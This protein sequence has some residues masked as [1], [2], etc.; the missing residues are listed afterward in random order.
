[1]WAVST[2]DQGVE[3]AFEYTFTALV[4]R[5]DVVCRQHLAVRDELT[6]LGECD[7]AA[8]AVRRAFFGEGNCR[9]SCV[10]ESPYNWHCD[11]HR[12]FGDTKDDEYY[13]M[14]AGALGGLDSQLIKRS[15]TEQQ[16]R[17][18]R[19]YEERFVSNLRYQITRL[20]R[21]V[22]GRGERRARQR[23]GDNAPPPRAESV[24]PTGQATPAQQTACSPED[25]AAVAEMRHECLEAASDFT[26]VQARE[27][28]I[29]YCVKTVDRG[30]DV[31]GK[32]YR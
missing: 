22:A 21:L 16:R 10:V 27:S 31:Q 14:K 15:V 7:S 23:S 29:V 19:Q 28:A 25:R 2:D 32:D 4:E 17:I 20:V 9:A 18:T 6:L 30:C 1:M 3:R 24:V 26:N 5:Q 8:D 12:V 13:V 11:R